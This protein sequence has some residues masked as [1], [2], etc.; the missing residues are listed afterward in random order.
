MKFNSQE[1]APFLEDGG[2]IVDYDGTPVYIGE[3]EKSP[4]DFV[5]TVFKNDCHSNLN[6]FEDLFNISFEEMLAV[7]MNEECQ[8]T[9]E[10]LI[11]EAFIVTTIEDIPSEEDYI[12][13]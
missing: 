7:L 2:V 10:E 9:P 8:Y 13:E 11:G 1:N 6:D 3:G 12:N 5:M 4:S